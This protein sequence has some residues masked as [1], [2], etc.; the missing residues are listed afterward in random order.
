V[1]ILPLALLLLAGCTMMR[2]DSMHPKLILTERCTVQNF[3]VGGV[4]LRCKMPLGAALEDEVARL[5]VPK[6]ELEFTDEN[7]EPT[8][9]VGLTGGQE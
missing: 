6:P 9:K 3:D 8:L 7:N 1:K 2:P 4:L 5:L